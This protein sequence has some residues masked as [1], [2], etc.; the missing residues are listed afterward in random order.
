[1]GESLG[2]SIDQLME[3]AG[4]SVACAV[5]D[6]YPKARFSR[7]LAIC[8]PGSKN[9]YLKVLINLVLKDNGGDALVASRHLVHF[10]YK[11]TILYPKETKNQLYLVI[12]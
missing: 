7:I 3:L 4:L 6:A 2:F 5:F 1:M 9:L 12:F 11:P 10:G 8:G